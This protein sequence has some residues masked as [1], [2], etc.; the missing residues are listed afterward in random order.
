MNLSGIQ[1]KPTSTSEN[2]ELTSAKLLQSFWI[3]WLL[4]FP[5]KITAKS[6]R[7]GSQWEMTRVVITFLLCTPSKN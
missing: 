3:H 7:A 5:T 1:A 4:P 6:K 2:T